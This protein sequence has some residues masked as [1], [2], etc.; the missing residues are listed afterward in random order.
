MEEFFLHKNSD[1]SQTASS[2]WTKFWLF[3]PDFCALQT[4]SNIVLSKYLSQGIKIERIAFLELNYCWILKIEKFFNVGDNQRFCKPSNF[5]S[6]H[7]PH[8]SCVPSAGTTNL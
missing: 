3:E 8:R 7:H 2:F 4:L 5:F 6:K 1:C